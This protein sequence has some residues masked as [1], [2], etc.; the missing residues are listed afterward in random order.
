MQNR[1][2]SWLKFNERVLEEAVDLSLPELER[3]KFVSIFTSNLDEFFMIRVGSLFQL[4]KIDKEVKDSRSKLTAKEQLDFIFEECKRL[5]K[6]KDEFFCKCQKALSEKSI[7][8]LSFDELD[9]DELKYVKKYFKNEISPILS[10]QIVGTH[11]P[12]PHIHNLAIN[13][14]GMLKYKKE[15][16][17]AIIP[18]PQMLDRI[19]IL[20]GENLRYISC[21]DIV[22]EYFSKVFEDYEI[23][24]KT[25]LVITRNADISPEEIRLDMEYDFKKLMKKTLVKRKRLSA[26]RAELNRE[27]SEDFIEYLCEKIKISREKFFVSSVPTDISYAFYLDKYLSE[28]QKL[29]L[30]YEEF[31]PSF[32]S[33]LCE[34]QSIMKQIMNKDV[35]ISLPFESMKPFLSL[36]KEASN[37]ENVISIKITIYR[38]AKNAKLVE[39]L[40][41][42]AENGIDVTIIIELRARFDEQNNIDWSEKLEEAGCVVIYGFEDY[43]IHSKICLITFKDKNKLNYITQIGTGNYNENTAKL[44]TDLSLMTSNQEIGIDAA[45][46]F[47]NMGIGNLKGKYEKL[48][49]APNSL[50]TN[51]INLIDR[52]IQKG[53]EGYIFLKLNSLTDIELIKKLSDASR[54]NVK[55]ELMI[56]GIIGILP[57]IKGYTDNIFIFSVVGRFLEHSR[58]Y[59]FGKEEDE[60]LY[61]SSADFMTRNTE[62]RVEVAC[63]ILSTDVKEKVKKLIEK[64]KKDNIKGRKILANGKFQKYKQEETPFDSH[65]FL[66]EDAYNSAQNSKACDE[67]IENSQTFM[68]K[69]KNF[70]YKN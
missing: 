24:E 40:C 53:K 33:E 8:Q 41:N 63:P 70:F 5:Y 27:I 19:I 52:E 66:I 60:K 61:I 28:E 14:C 55:I 58:I 43:K 10:P 37:S 49:V 30:S 38:L 36:I 15:I 57:N 31:T 67:E 9:D 51:I 11:H 26:V 25:R 54:N 16:K 45:E 47:K 50:K 13:I 4:S 7:K 23:L 44:Y 48:L 34:E 68:K 17:F 46:F 62:R 20:P 2:L 65:K 18:I 21:E 56:R 69:V 32:P 35:M 42:A 39:Y 59:L 22:F 64:A 6:I 1:E 3:L 12:F 29:E